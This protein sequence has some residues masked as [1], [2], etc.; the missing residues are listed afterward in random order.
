M[1]SSNIG[2]SIRELLYRTS[3]GLQGKG[4]TIEEEL[5][6]CE[7][8]IREYQE[9]LSNHGTAGGT[10]RPLRESDRE[11]YKRGLKGWKIRKQKLVEQ[12]QRF[13]FEEQRYRYLNLGD[14]VQNDDFMIFT[15]QRD[16][17]LESKKVPFAPREWEYVSGVYDVKIWMNRQ[18]VMEQ[19]RELGLP[20]PPIDFY[21]NL[22]KLE[23]AYQAK[24]ERKRISSEKLEE[25][26]KE[27]GI[28]LFDFEGIKS[29]LTAKQLDQEDR[30]LFNELELAQENLD[31]EKHRAILVF[32]DLNESQIHL[33]GNKP[34][35]APKDYLRTVSH[36]QGNNLGEE[37]QYAFTTF[38]KNNSRGAQGADLGPGNVPFTLQG[39]RDIYS[40]RLWNKG[41]FVLTH[42]TLDDIKGLAS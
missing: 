42:L 32:R 1:D 6:N 9:L 31:N 22:E 37:L 20:L 26:L 4:I 35:S 24:A 19:C 23:E 17:I 38:L 7:Q 29:N 2:E 18:E 34:E 21:R 3:E 25:R 41:P 16:K 27:L 39:N 36:L 33:Y 5:Y 13:L 10:I 8:R 40:V 14:T 30:L 15:Q 28:N 12:G 11:S